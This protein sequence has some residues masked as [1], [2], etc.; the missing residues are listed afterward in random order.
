[1][2]TEYQKMI[3]HLPSNVYDENDFIFVCFV[4]V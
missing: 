1:M 4:S 3:V 2:E